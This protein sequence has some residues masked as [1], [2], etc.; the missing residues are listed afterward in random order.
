MADFTAKDV[1]ALRDATGAGMLDAKR[2]LE[3]CDGDPQAGAQWLRQ[4]GLGTISDRAGRENEEGAV[5]AVI[6]GTVGSA[7]LVEIKT[8]TDFGAKSPDV[9]N[10]ANELAELVAAGGEAAIEARKDTLDDLKITLKENVELGAVVRFQAAPGNVLSRYVH[11][12]NGRG[13]NGVIVEMAGGDETLAHDV[14]VHV[15]F[16]KP[17]YVRREDVPEADVE[18]ERA[19]LEAETRA[20]GKPEAALPKIV[21]GKLGGWYKR[22]PGGV[23]ID[24]PYARDDKQT[25]GQVLGK[26]TVVRFAQAAIGG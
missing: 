19:A 21:D 6:D 15:A 16:G 18:R 17:R 7:A 1:K 23:L 22:V 8:E 2:A 4:R 11:E 13:V 24:Q 9:V 26:A 5:A 12:Q 25:V 10:L 20:Q 3:E 14:A